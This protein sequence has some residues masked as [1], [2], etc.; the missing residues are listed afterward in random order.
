MNGHHSAIRSCYKILSTAADLRVTVAVKER[1]AA[2]IRSQLST[3]P[4]PNTRTNIR[5]WFGRVAYNDSAKL[6]ILYGPSSHSMITT[7][8]HCYTTVIQKYNAC[9]MLSTICPAWLP[10][11]DRNWL[12]LKKYMRYRVLVPA[13]ILGLDSV[14]L[15]I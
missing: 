15:L 7:Q 11:A 14:K 6:S 5:Q 10:I 9:I 3:R 12:T 2:T 4:N 8:C 13:L 1:H